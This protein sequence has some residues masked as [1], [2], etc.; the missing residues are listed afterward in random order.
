M[1]VELHFQVL[2]R[3]IRDRSANT[4]RRVI[5]SGDSYRVASRVGYRI[6]LARFVELIQVAVRAARSHPSPARDATNRNLD[7]VNWISG[8]A[9][10]N[11]RPLQTSR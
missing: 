8:P 1:T 6:D 3:R 7:E 2:F 10:S 9:D 5:S 11:D 4:L